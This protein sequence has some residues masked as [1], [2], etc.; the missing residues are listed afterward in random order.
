MSYILEALKRSQ[1]ERELARVPILEAATLS[2]EDHPA[3]RGIPWA[4]I[5]A[6][7]AAVAVVVAVYTML[8]VSDG[9]S[10]LVR[11]PAG[12]DTLVSAATGHP[13][14][15][16]GPAAGPVP[17][18]LNLADQGVAQGSLR[19]LTPPSTAETQPSA[20]SPAADWSTGAVQTMPANPGQQ[21]VEAPLIEAPPPKGGG[22]PL[23][24]RDMVVNSGP[25]AAPLPVPAALND[26]D[27]QWEQQLQRQLG[28]DPATAAIAQ[29]L[30]KDRAKDLAGEPVHQDEG[31]TAVPTDLIADI[32]AF[33]QRVKGG[34]GLDKGKDPGA[35]P[36]AD[37]KSRHR[38]GRA[39]QSSPQ[40]PERSPGVLATPGRPVLPP[41]SHPP[42]ERV[43]TKG[44]VPRN[45]QAAEPDAIPPAAVPSQPEVPAQ[46][47]MPGLGSDLSQ[48]RLTPEQQANLPK[49]QMSVHVYNLDPSR[50]FI[51]IN[52]LKYGEGARTRE[53]LKVAEIRLDGA[54]L[55]YQGHPFFIHR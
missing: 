9:Q 33:K 29:D 47:V 37:D 3:P 17:M 50:R 22:A 38:A 10:A 27:A 40:A 26:M 41:L 46:R 11:G 30:A 42:P 25:G 15:R 21:P 32:D 36:V 1:T 45:P 52:G 19:S 53:G 20:V 31:L 16:I 48:L 24:P 12:A 39:A 2:I 7:C 44:L 5:A 55:D 28:S 34:Q 49:F 23:N 35:R 13:P 4:M 14:A 8:R 51:L 6:G 54:V 18:A 43:A